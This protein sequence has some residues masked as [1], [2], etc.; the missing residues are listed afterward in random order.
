VKESVGNIWDYY[1]KGSWVCITTNGNLK[2][3]GTAVMGKG[4]ALEAAHRI[5]NLP[6][7]LGQRISSYIDMPSKGNRL[8]PFPDIH[9]CCFPTKWNWWEKSDLCLIAVSASEL[10]EYVEEA[11]IQ[12]KTPIYLPRPG[13]ANGGLDWENVKPVLEHYLDD[14]FIVLMLS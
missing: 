13:C 1:S 5:P 10:V 14:R 6:K 12:I 2:S 8:N 4:I 7:M 11:H 9:L 3:D